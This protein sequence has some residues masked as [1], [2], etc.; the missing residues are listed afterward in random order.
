VVTDGTKAGT[1]TAGLGMVEIQNAVKVGTQYYLYGDKKLRLYNPANN[2]VTQLAADIGRYSVMLGHNGKLYFTNDNTTGSKIVLWESNG[3]TA[4]TKTTGVEVASYFLFNPTFFLRNN[5]LYFTKDGGAIIS[6]QQMNLSNN[7]LVKITDLHNASSLRYETPLIP[8][9]TKL[10]FPRLTDAEGNELWTSNLP[11]VSAVRGPD[12]VAER[13]RVFPNP[14]SQGVA[15]VELEGIYQ[16]VVR[17]ELFDALGRAVWQ[18]ESHKAAGKQ[19]DTLQWPEFEAGTY[20]L[21]AAMG[22]VRYAALVAVK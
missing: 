15:R 5:L 16:G 12:R 10:I 21:I 1:R 2:A 20:T 9:G 6:L 11:A 8:L 22:A 3:T 13:L 4:G 19:T 17:Y 7:A 14:V 18:G